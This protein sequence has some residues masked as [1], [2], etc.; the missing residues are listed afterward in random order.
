MLLKVL[1]KV[2][3]LICDKR[4][5]M[6]AKWRIT[7]FVS[8]RLHTSALS[9]LFS[10]HSSPMVT[11]SV[12]FKWAPVR[13]PVSKVCSMS[14]GATRSYR[15]GLVSFDRCFKSNAFPFNERL[16]ANGRTRVVAV[17][18]WKWSNRQLAVVGRLHS[19]LPLLGLSSLQLPS[20]EAVARVD[21]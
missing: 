6:Q 1:V 18:I 16:L 17:T 12:H 7:L 20:F 11:P 8:K 19:P 9:L 5:H 14:L 4:N 10:S 2:A 13:Y 3:W 21:F 15:P